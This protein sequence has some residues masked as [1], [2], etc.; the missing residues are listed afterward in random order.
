M[1]HCP[2]AACGRRLIHGSC[3]VHGEPPVA[4]APAVVAELMAER[5]PRD[6]FREWT[7]E[8]EQRIREYSEH[9]TGP[10]IAEALERTHKGVKHWFERHGMKNPRK[11]R[12]RKPRHSSAPAKPGSPWTEEELW[13]L[14]TG[15]LKTLYRSRSR[16]AVALKATRLGIPVRSGDGAMS[17]RQVS[18]SWNVHPNVVIEWIDRRLLPARRAG[19]MWRIEPDKAERIVP[20]LMKVAR[21]NHGRKAW[22]K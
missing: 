12:P 4:L 1:T 6:P 5:A 13:L 15:E 17:A 11:S 7:E 9:M 2:R 10:E 14:E 20:L 16:A 3:W 21:A 18:E 22:W 8:D 19:R